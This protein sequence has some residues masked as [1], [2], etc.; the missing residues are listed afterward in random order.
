MPKVTGTRKHKARELERL[1][2]KGPSLTENYDGSPYCSDQA[3]RDT[4][5]WLNSWVKPLID[6]LVP[7]LRKKG[8]K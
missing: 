4:K 7:E 8:G 6:E 5:L 1:I 3:M 2:K